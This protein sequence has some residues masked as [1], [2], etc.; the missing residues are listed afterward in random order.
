M[1]QKLS[2]IYE[3]MNYCV[4]I[5]ATLVFY[6]LA[7]GYRSSNLMFSHDSLQ[8]IYQVEWQH[9]ISLGRYLQ[10]LVWFIRGQLTMPWL[11]DIGA[12]VLMISSVVMVVRIFEVKKYW[13][14]IFM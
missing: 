9:K 14:V 3:N 6:V 10:P 7:H 1:K 12:V 2:V 11:V 4:A 5:V 8:T 13:M